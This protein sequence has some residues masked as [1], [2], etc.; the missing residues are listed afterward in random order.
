VNPGALSTFATPAMRQEELRSRR[1]YTSDDVSSQALAVSSSQCARQ[2]VRT[3]G[4]GIVV[5]RV[6]LSVAP[7]LLSQERI[8]T[9]TG[10]QEDNLHEG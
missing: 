8:E 9:P 2:S 7:T 6:C 10:R 5:Q 3:V 4:R 1:A